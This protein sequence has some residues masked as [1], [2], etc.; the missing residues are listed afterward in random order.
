MHREYFTTIALVAGVLVLVGVV[1]YLQFESSQP[2]QNSSA[3]TT[4][5]TSSAPATSSQTQVFDS[6]NKYENDAYAFSFSY[7]ESWKKHSGDQEEGT[8]VLVRIVNPSRA[9]KP[10]TDAPT[11]QLYVQKENTNECDFGTEVSANPAQFAGKDAYDTGW[12]K[13][14]S[15]GLPRRDICIPFADMSLTISMSAFDAESKDVMSQMLR[16]FK[17]DL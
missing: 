4:N 5:A 8:S 17:L 3:T 1:G 13:G 11:E 14:L 16:S 15:A 10:D 6:W 2:R 7:P 9:G 12:R